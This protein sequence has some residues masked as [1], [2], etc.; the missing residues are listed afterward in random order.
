[1]KAIVLFGSP[2]SGKGT[3]AKMLTQCLGIP[4]YLDR[5][6]AAGPHPPRR[7][8]TGNGGGRDHAVGRPGV[9]RSGQPDGGGAAQPA[10]CDATVLSWM[11]TRGRWIRPTTCAGWLDGR[12]IREVVIYLA[13]DYNIVIA[14]LTGRRQCPRCGTLYNLASQPPRVDELCDLDGEKLVIREDDNEAV[15]RERLDA[16]ERQTRPVLEYFRS[17]GRR[18]V[19]VDASHDP[20]ETVFQEDLPG[21]GERMIVRK[22]AAE[23][24]KMRRS[25]LL[26]WQILQKLKEI[27]VEGVSTWDLEVAAEKMM[28]DAGARPAFKGYYVPAAG[29]ALQ[30]CVV[31]LGEQRDRPRDA[32][33][34]AR[35]EEGRYRFDRHRGEAGRVLWRFGHH[36][37]DRRSERGDARSSSR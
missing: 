24:E 10:G 25:G 26:V 35:P 19:E 12:G 6:H 2:G 5:G 20:P 13:V 9:R 31:H 3:Q 11:A 22:T 1:M 21:D 36:R 29:E 14:R 4:A 28:A 17:A 8:G 15:I 37:A 23:L 7:G 34:E 27:A 18:V 33:S 30:V 16:Y 32:E